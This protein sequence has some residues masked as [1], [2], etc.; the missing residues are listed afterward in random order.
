M[1]SA[2][3]SNLVH[4][5]PDKQI[6]GALLPSPFDALFVLEAEQALPPGPSCGVEEVDPGTASGPA[7]AFVVVVV[8]ALD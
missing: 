3:A 7:P 5:V 8:R 6:L 4:V 1:R 2:R